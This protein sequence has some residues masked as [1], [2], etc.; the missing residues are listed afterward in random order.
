M[1]RKIRYHIVQWNE[2]TQLVE[3]FRI[4][5]DETK[6]LYSDISFAKAKKKSTRSF[7]QELGEALLVD[8]PAG[9]RLF[10]L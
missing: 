1:A 7:A 10:D 4:M 9:R 8:S 3:I 6:V 5:D 2:E